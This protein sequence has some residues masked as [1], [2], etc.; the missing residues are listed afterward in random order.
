MSFLCGDKMWRQT[1]NTSESFG[2][3][4]DGDHKI[5]VFSPDVMHLSLFCRL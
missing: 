2:G 5:T 1:R 3:D 4:G